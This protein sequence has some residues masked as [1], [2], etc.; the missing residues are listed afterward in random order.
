MLAF[1]AGWLTGGVFCL[2][3]Q[4]AGWLAGF[5]WNQGCVSVYVCVPPALRLHA[6]AVLVYTS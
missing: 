2:S 6:V 4:W 3:S 1:L 5:W